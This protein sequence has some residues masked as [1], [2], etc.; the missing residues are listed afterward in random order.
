MGEN[1]G[2]PVCGPNSLY[3]NAPPGLEALEKRTR[4]A[5]FKH[6][7]AM[8]P[9]VDNFWCASRL[10]TGGLPRY[11]IRGV[12]RPATARR[13]T[14]GAVRARPRP[15]L[16]PPDAWPRCSSSEPHA[17]LCKDLPGVWANY[18]IWFS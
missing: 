4:S 13:C 10:V 6:Y 12:L 3:E 5:L 18:S 15:H 9:A 8:Y 17:R 14:P 11:K 16:P 2:S 7:E 1:K